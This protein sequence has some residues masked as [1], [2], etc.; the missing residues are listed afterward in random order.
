MSNRGACHLEGGYTAAKDYCA[1]YAEWPGDRIEGSALISKN[2][3]LGNTTVDIIGAC[4]Y[5]SFSITLDEYAL[6]VNAVTGLS[7]NAGLLQKI[8]WRTLTL[9][10]LFNIRCG[11]TK[12]DDWPACALLRNTGRY[13]R[14]NCRM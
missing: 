13:Q 11:F 9:E 12:D 4:V 7:Y 2:A 8:A 3:A 10:R 1:G 14:A 6:L 5:S